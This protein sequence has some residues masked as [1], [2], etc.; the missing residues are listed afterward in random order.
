MKE[1]IHI[2]LSVRIKLK[3]YCLFGTMD[4]PDARLFRFPPLYA[5]LSLIVS[6]IMFPA[7]VCMAQSPCLCY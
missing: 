3:C 6:V 5:W 7:H 2:I 4:I 1:S